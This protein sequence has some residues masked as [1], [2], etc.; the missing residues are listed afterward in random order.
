MFDLICKNIRYIVP[1]VCII[2]G[3]RGYCGCR[4]VFAIMLRL[5]SC[6]IFLCLA[7]VLS[8]FTQDVY[9]LFSFRG[10]HRISVGPEIYFMQRCKRGGS[11]Q[12]GFLYGGRFSYDRI[13]RSALYWGGDILYAVGNLCG[14]NSDSEELRTCKR[15]FEV[16]GRLGY[17]LKKKW[18]CCYWLTPYF[19]GGFFQG[20]NQFIDPSPMQYK[21]INRYP[22]ISLGFLSRVDINALFGIGVDFKAKYSI[23]ACSKIT[24]DA[25]PNVDHARFV[26]E[27]KFSYDVDVPLYFNTCICAKKVDIRFVPFYRFRHYGAHENF[28]FDF[29]DT[30]FHMY[31]ARL[32]FSLCF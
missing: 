7:L 16:E 30:R 21:V 3:S 20:T 25:D 13:R 24:G 23:G 5:K 6:S 19:G 18:G 28:P 10:P 14:H 11:K 31:G 15:D 4:R 1:N 17:T 29:I 2:W 12:R 27:D 9:G 26:I 32:M 8:I 22:F